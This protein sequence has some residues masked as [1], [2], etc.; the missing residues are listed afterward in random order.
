MIDDI[1]K[2]KLV[3]F[4]ERIMPWQ[5]NIKCVPGWSIPGPDTAS[6]RHKEKSEHDDEAVLS[7]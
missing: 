5:F 3:S 6:R 4:I 2:S 1:D 7:I